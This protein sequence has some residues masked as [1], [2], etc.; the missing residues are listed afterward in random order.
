MAVSSFVREA[1]RD[2]WIGRL[3]TDENTRSQISHRHQRIV[4]ASGEITDDCSY[5]TR[6]RNPIRQRNILAKGQQ[7]NLIILS[8]K[9]T[10]FIYEHGGIVNAVIGRSFL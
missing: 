6:T 9:L 8:N 7:A 1:T 10:L 2:R 3:D 4:R 5:Q